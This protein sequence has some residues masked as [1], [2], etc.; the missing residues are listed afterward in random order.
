MWTMWSTSEGL[1]IV[2]SPQTVGGCA[3]ALSRSFS[4]H[5][6]DGGL[7][8]A[9]DDAL[10]KSLAILFDDEEGTASLC[11]FECTS[12]ARSRNVAAAA[13]TIRRG[14]P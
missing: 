3:H 14:T 2:L 6:D 11:L 10:A 13:V 7:A 4:L 5:L 12:H 8:L 1:A 9:V